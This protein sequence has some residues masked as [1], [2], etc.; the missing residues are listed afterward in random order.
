ML[1]GGALFGYSSMLA[2]QQQQIVLSAILAQQSVSTWDSLG[3]HP[4]SLQNIK[5]ELWPKHKVI[6]YTGDGVPVGLTSFF[7]EL[8]NEID[9]WLKL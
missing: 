3:Q 6:G 8:R 7:D 1:G 5:T 2:Q 9:E 4:L